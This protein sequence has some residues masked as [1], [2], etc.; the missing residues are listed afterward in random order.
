MKPYLALVFILGCGRQ[1]MSFS[2]SGSPEGFAQATLAAQAWNDTCGTSITLD[3]D[4][5]LDEV[6]DINGYSL[7]KTFR[8]GGSVDR[9]AFVRSDRA[10]ETIVHEFGHAL[11]IH[12]HPTDKGVMAEFHEYGSVLTQAECQMIP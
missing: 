6:S 11:G 4:I 8:T 10:G 12:G 9:V 5:P 2:Y 3:G 7:G 1:E